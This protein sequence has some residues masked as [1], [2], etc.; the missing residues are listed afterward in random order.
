MKALTYHGARDVRVQTVSDPEI[1]A[2]DDILVKVTATAISGSDLHVYRGRVPGMK[3]GDILGREFMGIVQET[4]SE[5]TRLA[6]GDRVI[7]PSII[8][9]GHCRFCDEQLFAA[10]DGT[11]EIGRA[12]CRE[13]VCQYV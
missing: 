1:H 7:V 11:G 2:S 12:S 8:A 3:P 6:P 9:C 10:C 5:V 13:R 4:G